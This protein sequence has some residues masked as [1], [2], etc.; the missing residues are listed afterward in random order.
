MRVGRDADDFLRQLDGLIA[1][2][3]TGPRAACSRAMDAESWDAKVKEMSSVV[4]G[5]LQRPAQ[6]R[7][8]A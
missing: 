3:E 8:R 4:E 5:F 2:R 7:A 1:S 6:R